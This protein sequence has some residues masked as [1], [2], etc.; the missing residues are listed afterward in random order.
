M[1]LFITSFLRMILVHCQQQDSEISQIKQI[2]KYHLAAVQWSEA[3][4]WGRQRFSGGQH[5]S[6][7]SEEAWSVSI[8]YTV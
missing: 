7:N 8:Y 6:K 2:L 3:C 5:N 4:H 1:N